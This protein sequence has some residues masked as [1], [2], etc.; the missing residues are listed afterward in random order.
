VAIDTQF[1]LV[2]TDHVQSRVV[3]TARVPGPPPGGN[4]DGVV[5]APIWHFWADGDTIAVEVSVD[6]HAGMPAAVRKIARIGRRARRSTITAPPNAWPAP[7]L[8]WYA[9]ARAEK[10]A[11][12][13]GSVAP[14]RARRVKR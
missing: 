2:V 10:R 3:E 12:F 5:S 14:P 9:I 11:A 7:D 6:V 8:G 1:A 4:S 13:T